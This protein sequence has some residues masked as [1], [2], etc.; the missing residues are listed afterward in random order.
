MRIHRS[1]QKINVRSERKKV[2]HKITP[3]SSNLDFFSLIKIVGE[4]RQK[5][6][7]KK[8]IICFTCKESG[9]YHTMCPNGKVVMKARKWKEIKGSNKGRALK[10]KEKVLSPHPYLSVKF[11]SSKHGSYYSKYS[12]MCDKFIM[13]RVSEIQ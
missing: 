3:K 5:G 1:L 4:I 10:I 6:I 11:N 9:H 8:H 2:N 7:K 12:T 13:P